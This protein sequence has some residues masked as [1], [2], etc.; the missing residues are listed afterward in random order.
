MTGMDDDRLWAAIH[1]TD[2]ERG[3]REYTLRR[4]ICQMLADAT[5]QEGAPARVSIPV[6][7]LARLCAVAKFTSIIDVEDYVAEWRKVHRELIKRRDD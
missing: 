2:F 7:W 1:L 5:W 4:L 3:L 6:E